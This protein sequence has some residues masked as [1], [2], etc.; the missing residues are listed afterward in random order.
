MRDLSL[1]EHVEY[2]EYV[3]YP[4]VVELYGKHENTDPHHRLLWREILA[5]FKEKW[6]LIKKRPF[7]IILTAVAIAALPV[8]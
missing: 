3:G 7:F 1:D 8:P 6:A 4:Y 5:Y 2:L